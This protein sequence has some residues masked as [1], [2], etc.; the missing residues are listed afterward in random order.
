M[1]AILWFVG[2]LLIGLVAIYVTVLIHLIKA[3]M[4]GYCVMEWWKE[5]YNLDHPLSTE[6]DKYQF[7]IGMIIWPVRLYEFIE[8]IPELYDL[9]DIRIN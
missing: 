8:V 9:Y 4:K 2:Y 6:Q 1:L 5:N 3:D 7:L